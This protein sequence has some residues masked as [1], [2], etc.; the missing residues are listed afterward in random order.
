MLNVDV[1]NRLTIVHNTQNTKCSDPK[2]RLYAILGIVKDTEDI[3]IDYSIPV[4]QVYRNWAKKR[5]RRTKNLDILSACADSSRSGDLPS[6]VPDLRRPFGQDKLLWIISQ[7]LVKESRRPRLLLKTTDPA[8][9]FE[10]R[11][12]HFSD[13]GHKLSVSGRYLGRIV[14]LTGVGDIVTNLLDPTDLNARLCQM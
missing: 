12:L 13:D 2:D 1:K 7:T 3:E 14:R 10:S 4:E 8:A 11:G 6:W 5:I 9:K